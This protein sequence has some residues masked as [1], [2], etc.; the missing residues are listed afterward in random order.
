MAAELAVEKASSNQAGKDKKL[1]ESSFV[2]QLSKATDEI[3]GL[4]ELLNQKEVYVGE[5]VQTLTQAQKDLRVSSNRVQFLESSL[6]P[7]QD[8]YDAA[9][10]KKEELRSEIEQW[11]RDYEVL[12]DKAVVEVSWAFL[13]TRHDTLMEARREGFELAAEI[14]KIKE[15]IEK[16]QQITPGEATV[17]SPFGQ[18]VSPTTDDAILHPTGSDSAPQ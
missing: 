17:Q 11:E 16:T 13:N 5:L 4:K 1:L 12:E 7:L 8:S 18:V 2:E 14:A 3:R 6:A 15:T 10:T 9:L